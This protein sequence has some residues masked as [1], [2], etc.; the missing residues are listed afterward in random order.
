MECRDSCNCS[1]EV[2]DVKRHLL[3]VIW[4]SS[5]DPEYFNFCLG[6]AYAPTFPHGTVSIVPADVLCK[7]SSRTSQAGDSF[8]FLLHPRG[9]QTWSSLCTWQRGG[10]SAAE[11]AE[12]LQALPDC[13]QSSCICLNSGMTSLGG[14]T[15]SCAAAKLQSLFTSTVLPLWLL[16]FSFVTCMFFKT[17]TNRKNSWNKKVNVNQT[18]TH[19]ALNPLNTQSPACGEGTWHNYLFQ[20]FLSI[21]DI[22]KVTSCELK[23]GK[24]CGD[25]LG[26]KTAGFAPRWWGIITDWREPMGRSAVVWHL[27]LMRCLFKDEAAK[28]Y[29]SSGPWSCC[30]LSCCDWGLL[31]WLVYQPANYVF[32]F[33]RMYE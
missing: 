8:P 26:P 20:K 29:Y 24:P 25:A 21:P 1:C 17:P 19:I 7:W 30:C 18:C 31:L 4:F 16:H 32:F 9:T 3:E 5:R 15:S 2:I 13:H 11:Q 23:K 28:Y 14:R 6:L 22:R 33:S 10:G 12:W 27:V